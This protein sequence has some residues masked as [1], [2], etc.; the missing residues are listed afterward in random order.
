MKNRQPNGRPKIYPG[1][2]GK[3]HAYVTMGLKPDGSLD[4]RHRSGRT[5][6]EVERKISELEKK[7]DAGHIPGKGKAPTVEQWI[8]TYLDTIAVRKL[9]P[10]TFD[11]YWSKARNWIIPGLGKHRIDQLQPEH[12]DALYA[13]MFTAGKASSHVLKVHRII[14][15]ALKIAM[16]REMIARNVAT[17]VDAPSVDE[18]EFEPLSEAETHA[19]LLAAQNHPNAA[20]WSVGLALGL[21]QGEA[22]GLRWKYVD[23]DAGE[24]RVWWQIQRTTWRHGCA[25][26]HKCGERLH[27]QPC[28]KGCACHK[29]RPSCTPDCAKP[30]HQGCPKACTP[31]CTEHARVCPKRVGGGL[32]FREPK[33]KS[34]RTIPLPPELIP[35]LKAHRNAQ[36]RERFAK[37]AAWNDLDLVFS[38]PDGN[39][40]DPRDDFAAWKAI[41]AE[42]GVRDVR[43]HDGRHTSAT[44]LIEYG[45][46]VRVVMAILGHSDLRVTMRYAHASNPLLR[47]AAA[48]M[49]RGLWG[50]PGFEPTA[51]DG[52]TEKPLG[53]S[54]RE[55]TAWSEKSPL[56]ELNRR[57]THYECV[58]LTD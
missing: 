57:P 55:G 5:A 12:L 56:S 26:P 52:A 28:P 29:H 19:V 51:T 35:I 10:R 48:R 15:R 32:V 47:D 23:M 37:G 1:A 11:D 2:D 40:I 18:V 3:F 42:A 31:N 14:S 4:R 21:R 16:R 24:V 54:F 46:D 17:L 58:A 38:Q 20:R 22:L 41:L 34:K 53:R 33:G 30:S 36:R 50:A 44:L 27:K 25:D 43:V 9:A 13:S 45:V 39:A 8:T 49:G 7:R 6:T